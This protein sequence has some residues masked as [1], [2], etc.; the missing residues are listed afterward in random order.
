M[1]QGLNPGALRPRERYNHR[2]LTSVKLA[3][4]GIC[5][6]DWLHQNKPSSWETQASTSHLDGCFSSRSRAGRTSFASQLSIRTGTEEKM[7]ADAAPHQS[8]APREGSTHRM[9]SRPASRPSRTLIHPQRVGVARRRQGEVFRPGRRSRRARRG[10]ERDRFEA[11]HRLAGRHLL[12]LRQRRSHARAAHATRSVGS[13]WMMR[14][15]GLIVRLNEGQA[16]PR[17]ESWND[18][19]SACRR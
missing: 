9:V 2:A 5:G 12:R 16:R 7:T 17:T 10:H 15:S 18:G 8:R 11:S 14:Q 1:N 4:Y 6:P 19:I 13:N 3:R